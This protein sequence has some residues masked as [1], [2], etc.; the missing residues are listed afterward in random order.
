MDTQRG[1]YLFH[2]ITVVPRG[3]DNP[4][5]RFKQIR[6]RRAEGFSPVARFAGW[7]VLLNR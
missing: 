2:A 3:P 6:K 5:R 4:F 1:R 7:S